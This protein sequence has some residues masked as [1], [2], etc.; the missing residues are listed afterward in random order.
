M[1]L[2]NFIW[3]DMSLLIYV[4]Y[5]V[6]WIERVVVYKLSEYFWNSVRKKN[7]LFNLYKI[8]VYMC[9]VDI[10][11]IFLLLE[12]IEVKFGIVVIFVKNILFVDDY[13]D[14]VKNMEI[15]V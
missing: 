15:F 14:V 10:F 1:C 2:Y 6:F 3:C 4:Y 7:Y 5:V 11:I 8:Y 12:I 13:V 9:N